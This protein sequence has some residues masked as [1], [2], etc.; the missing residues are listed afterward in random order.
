MENLV[1]DDELARRAGILWMKLQ[2]LPQP[3][4]VA[5]VGLHE[6]LGYS[7][8][9][10]ADAVQ[11]LFARRVSNPDCSYLELVER[12]VETGD[13]VSAKVR[14]VDRESAV[15]TTRHELKPWRDEGASG[16]DV[17]VR[18]LGV[19]TL[20]EQR[21]KLQEHWIHT[22]SSHA[23]LVL[24]GIDA[25]GHF[26]YF[27]RHNVGN[28]DEENMIG[29][30]LVDAFP[31]V[32]NAN[33]MLIRALAG[34][35]I[36]EVFE[37]R[38]ETYEVHCEP[39]NFRDGR[40]TEVVGAIIDISRQALLDQALRD[41]ENYLHTI[42]HT[43]TDG[44]LVNDER[45]RIEFANS[46]LA[47]LL[48]TRP[49]DMIG[50]TI[51]DYMDDAGRARSQAKL[52]R[53][54]AG[55]EERFDFYFIRADG[56][57]LWCIISAKPMYDD[58]GN[59]R[60]S[61]VA[62]TD[63][64][65]R[66][67]AEDALRHA[68]DQLE[69]RVRERTAE[70]ATANSLLQQEVQVRRQAEENA[71][72]A[73]RSKSAFLASM[74]HELRTPLN[75]IIGYNEILLEDVAAD[76]LPQ[77]EEDL[78]R[79]H[80]S[81]NHLLDLINDILDLSKIE[82]AK[83]ELHTETFRLGDI[84]EELEATIKPLALKNSNTATFSCDTRNLRISTDRTKVK[85]ILLNLLSNACKFT[86]S[87]Q[88]NMEIEVVTRN[89]VEWFSATCQDTGIGIP[90]AQHEKIFHAFS[91]TDEGAA[92]CYGGTGLGLTIS[93]RLTQMLGG[94]IEVESQVGVGSTFRVQFPLRR[95]DD[96]PATHEEPVRSKRDPATVIQLR[97]RQ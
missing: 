37:H 86:E 18:D 36:N 7:Q 28:P 65:R 8:K 31:E 19:E 33:D 93:K 49:E 27:E 42:I 23:P 75:A 34:L 71:I 1:L 91:Q 53:R 70:L 88:V 81:A 59:H 21:N 77:F 15:H 22:V 2:L 39:A 46:R 29:R 54:R 66:K 26:T 5:V 62:V 24:F 20:L 6:L 87:G 83:M 43:I 73:N 61:L 56:T 10:Q 76:G 60:G 44:I 4:L 74:S 16:V 96:E 55:I 47:S 12:A 50:K 35:P 85:Q 92:K 78:R 13:A 95:S 94:D 64:S 97:P 63:I 9:P 69:Q 58:E 38:G 25:T 11:T 79:I 84:V 68:R 40:G 41:N 72:Q 45:G 89:G 14:V 51:F 90:P 57:K 82:A 80:W 52:A 30:N 48:G 67:Q 3:R 32:Q 17:V